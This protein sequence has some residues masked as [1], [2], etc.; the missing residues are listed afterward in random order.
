M[1]SFGVAC[2]PASCCLVRDQSLL[3]SIQVCIFARPGRD[4]RRLRGKKRSYK[5]VQDRYR[6]EG[7]GRGEGAT[8]PRCW[9]LREP[10]VI[11][12]QA[13]DVLVLLP[14]SPLRACLTYLCGTLLSTER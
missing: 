3:A 12:T 4:W 10:P 13:Q 11:T 14:P 2:G 1:K 5:R 6:W 9:Q 7:R 8:L